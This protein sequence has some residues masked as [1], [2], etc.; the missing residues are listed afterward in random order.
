MK[1]EIFEYK[2]ISST[3]DRLKEMVLSGASSGTAVIAESQS[4]GRGR[5]GKSFSSPNGGV[6]FSVYFDDGFVGKENI[7]FVTPS[8]AVLVSKCIEKVCADDTKIKWV[9]DIYVGNKKVC[10]ILTEKTIGGFVLGIGINTSDSVL[11][12]DVLGFAGKISANRREILSSLLENITNLNEYVK[13]PETVDYYRKKSFLKNKNVFFTKN[14]KYYSGKCVGIGD[15][16]SLIVDVGN[17]ITALSSGEVSVK[18][19]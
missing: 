13:G 1:L 16:F 15:D 8:A 10:G 3:S 14:G 18:W 2:E 19:D 11:E 4:S 17:E 6:Y 5:Q 9:N 12:S 7:G